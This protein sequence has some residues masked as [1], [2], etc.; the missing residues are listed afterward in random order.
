MGGVIP[1]QGGHE[2]GRGSPGAAEGTQHC[3]RLVTL[4]FMASSPPFCRGF[5]WLPTSRDRDRVLP[6]ELNKSHTP[7]EPVQPD[8]SPTR[9]A[10]VSTG[11]CRQPDSTDSKPRSDPPG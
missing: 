10:S 5:V 6:R 11:P 4:D 1:L 3:S 2:S 9:R 8:T 7:R